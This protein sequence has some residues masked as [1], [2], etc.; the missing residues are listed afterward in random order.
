MDE[1][2]ESYYE[3]IERGSLQSARAVVPVLLTFV[4]P[5]RVLDVGCG[6]GAWLRVLQEHGVADVWGVDTSAVPRQA[7]LFEEHRFIETDSLPN[8][9]APGPFDL[10]ISLEVAEHLPEEAADGLIASLTASSPVVLFSAAIPGQGGAHHINEQWPDYWARK[11]QAHDYVCIDCLRPRLWNNAEIRFWFRQN[12]LIFVKRTHVIQV[13]ALA[14]VYHPESGEPLSLVHPEL[15][16]RRERL[17][18]AKA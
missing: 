15:Y 10:A 13:P 11:F 1:Y 16:V 14:R 9:E 7:L 17:R 3:H 4:Q 2:T 5:A 6:T 8:F 18:L 12:L